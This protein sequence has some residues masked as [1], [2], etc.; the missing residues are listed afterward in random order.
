M[1]L[2]YTLLLY[3]LTPLL[4]AR[5]LWR[6]RQIRGYRQGMGERFGLVPRPAEGV[7]VWVHGVSVGESLAA[8]PMIRRLVEIHGARRVWVTTT[9]PTGSDRIR[10]ALG[11]RVIHTY[12]PY[13]LPGSVRRF[14]DRARP[15]QVVIMETEL[16]PHLFRQLRQRGIPLTIANARLSP[17]SFAGYSRVAGFTRSVLGDVNL[18]A[19]QSELDAQRFAQLGAPRV[20][21]LGNL[22]FDIEPPQ[23]QVVSG[24]SMRRWLGQDRP[25]WI[26]AST[27][28][29]E[30]AAALDAHRELRRQ[31]PAALL[32]LVP[33]DPRRFDDVASMIERA[34]FEF[35]RRKDWSETAPGPPPSAAVLLGDSLGEMWMY[36]AAADIAFV[37]GSLVPVGGHNVLE[38]A[39]L[40]L[41]VLFGPHMHNFLAPRELLLEAGAAQELRRPAELANAVA[42][43]FGDPTRRQTMGLAGQRAVMGNRGALERLLQHLAAS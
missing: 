19:A 3:L 8:L 26:A 30:E 32:I 22:K 27:H 23:A 7:A 13:D 18:V 41:P 25:V 10:A 40:G 5:L 35:R 2:L 34:G 24:Q 37:G 38:P 43:A 11:D 17:R 28:E 33:R 21:N 42:D 16:W 4:V 31:W 1:R 36:L 9:T 15:Q 14:L 39:T 6:S 12:L 20:E 29:G